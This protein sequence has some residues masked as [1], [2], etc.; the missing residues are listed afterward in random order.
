LLS[1]FAICTAIPLIHPRPPLNVQIALIF[2]LN[3]IFLYFPLIMKKH[4]FGYLE[5]TTKY[6]LL[7]FS[8]KKFFRHSSLAEARREISS[9]P[10]ANQPLIDNSTGGAHA[11]GIGPP[12]RV[13]MVQLPEK[14]KRACCS[15][16]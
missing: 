6:F 1:S 9:N 14:K 3:L 7:Y 10:A 16:Q 5:P 13:E 11:D 4:G 12:G 2:L 15:L 8:L